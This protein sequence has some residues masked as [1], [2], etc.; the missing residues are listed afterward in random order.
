M[1]ISAALAVAIAIPAGWMVVAPPNQQSLQCAQYAHRNWTVKMDGGLLDIAPLQERSRDDLPFVPM[2]PAG[3]IS[4]RGD[5]GDR[6]VL[7]VDDGWLVGYDDGQWDGSLWWFSRDGARADKLFGY[8]ASA[9]T[10][11]SSV[12]ASS[13]AS[14]TYPRAGNVRAIVRTHDGILALTGAS[15]EAVDEGGALRLDRVGG[16]WQIRPLAV[17]DG[18]PRAY[19]V[20]NANALLVLTDN[21]ISRLSIKKSAAAVTPFEHFSMKVDSLAIGPSGV[22]FVGMQQYV[23]R[24]AP[25]KGVYRAQWYA[26]D[27]C[28]VFSGNE[29]NDCKCV[30]AIGIPSYVARLTGR[31]SGPLDIA[32]GPDGNLWYSEAQADRIGRIT[33]AGGVTEFP[34][35]GREAFTLAAL[36]GDAL[37]FSVS[38]TS[39]AKIGVDGNIT[40]IALPK[41]AGWSPTISALTAGVDGSLWFVANGSTRIAR[42]N[43]DGTF[44]DYPLPVPEF[45]RVDAVATANGAIWFTAMSADQVGIVTPDGTARLYAIP[46]LGSGPVFPV[47]GP[48]GAVWFLESISGNL[49]SV[50]ADGRVTEVPVV[51]ES[52]SGAALVAGAAAGFVFGPDGN[53][54]LTQPDED[55]IVRITPTGAATTIATASGSR[56]TGIAAGPDGNVW[57]TEFGRGKIG[58]ITPVGKITEFALPP[59]TVVRNL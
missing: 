19:A 37:W 41:V 50:A 35:G 4:G 33:P 47:R 30:G 54:W 16:R 55:S 58:R 25:A 26:P 14:Q 45:D 6:H 23:A 38:S 44:K 48:G 3:A 46:T 52:R 1:N 59:F 13:D 18:A 31:N 24:L 57:F 29:L 15:H 22:L 10:N 51:A 42:L 53:F 43:P 2:V 28:P 7:K 40:D 36:A 17:L 49:A 39:V 5:T 56:P 20:E 8:D 32:V 11:V 27:D 34:A 21:G 9:W 12:A